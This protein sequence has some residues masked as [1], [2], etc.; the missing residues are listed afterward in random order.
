MAAS[1]AELQ[2]HIKT[3]SPETERPVRHGTVAQ[4]TAYENGYFSH[5][6]QILKQV[7]DD[8]INLKSSIM[9][10]KEFNKLNSSHYQGGKPT[11][12][13]HKSGMFSLSSTA[14]ERIGLNYGDKV[15][16][17]QNEE[18]PKDWYLEKTTDDKGFIMRGKGESEY[19]KKS[20]CF[21]SQAVRISILK[22]L[23]MPESENITLIV[24]QK[25]DYE[26]VELFP[27]ITKH[28]ENNYKQNGPK[29]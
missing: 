5:S 13:T 3:A 27:L 26:G 11:I 19:L 21:A 22:S 17:H 16:L 29:S 1:A 6:K 12:R 18:F 23:S 25:V 28:A 2:Q 14:S 15:I 24:G 8:I 4:G 9:K 7:Q 10:L 20:L